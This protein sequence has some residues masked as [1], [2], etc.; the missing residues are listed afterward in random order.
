LVIGDKAIQQTEREVMTMAVLIEALSV[1]VR[2][3][4]IID[5]YPGGVDQY[6]V[7]CPN[8]TLCLDD[9]LVRVGFMTGHD[10]FDFIGSLERLGLKYIDDDEFDEIAVVDQ[11]D[12]I[13]RPCDWLEYMNLVI[14]EGDIRVSICRIKGSAID[15]V[16]FPRGWVYENSLSKKNITLDSADFEG[17]MTFL[18]REGGVEFYLDKVTGIETF[19]K[20][21]IIRNANA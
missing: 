21:T 16:A 5:K 18:R 20:R 10:A 15:C 3:E 6:I 11:Y 13:V 4:T 19:V 1:V 17:R 2:L 8:N 14:F 9:D 7:D 12:G